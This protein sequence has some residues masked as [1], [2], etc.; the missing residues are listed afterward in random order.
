MLNRQLNAIGGAELYL[1]S[2]R[3]NAIKDITKKTD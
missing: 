1:E 3:E 2:T